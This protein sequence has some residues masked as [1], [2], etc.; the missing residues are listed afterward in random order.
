SIN[1]DLPARGSV[2]SLVEDHIDAKLL[3]AGTEFALYFSL[4]GGG[5]WHR[6]KSGL[7]TVAIKDLAIQRAMS[8]LVVG[9]FG[10]GFYVLDDYSPL[11]GTTPETLE[12]PA[13]IFP[14]RDG[15]L[16]MPTAQFGG[17][18]KAFLGEAFYTAENPPFGTSITYHLKDALPSKKQKRK[19]AEKKPNAPYTNAE[20]LRAAADAEEPEILPT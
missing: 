6:L 10:R 20:A 11:R 2:L 19:E 7:P 5:K 12:K 13:T 17:R 18:G 15:F 9:T 8:D 14:V 16:Y 1:G 3:F 4:D